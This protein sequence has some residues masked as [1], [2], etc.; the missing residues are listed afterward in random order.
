MTYTCTALGTSPSDS[1]LARVQG[2]GTK[3]GNGRREGVLVLVLN[4]VD[5]LAW[6]ELERAVS[7][8]IHMRSIWSTVLTIFGCN[9]RQNH[10]K[11]HSGRNGLNSTLAFF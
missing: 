10:S 5:G 1:G 9:Y 8:S 11:H 3:G 6:G 7:F 4:G 2:N